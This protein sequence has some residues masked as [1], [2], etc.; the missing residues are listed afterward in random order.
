VIFAFSTY[1]CYIVQYVEFLLADDQVKDD[2][3][4]QAFKTRARETFVC[5]DWDFALR[6]CGAFLVAFVLG[7]TGIHG[8]GAKKGFWAVAPFDS[9]IAGTT[10]YLM[11]A[12]GKGGSAL[13]KNVG[14]FLGTGGGTLLGTM[15]FHIGVDCTW[16]GTLVGMVALL[17]LQFFSFHL[18]FN[19]SQFGYV[20]LLLAA[21][22]GQNLLVPCGSEMTEA[23]ILNIIANQFYA[24]IA[25]TVAELL[26]PNAKSSDL[27]S[28]SFA[29]GNK[30]I[31]ASWRVYLGISS[32]PVSSLKD[33]NTLGMLEEVRGLGKEA[34]IEPRMVR[35]PWRDD[36]WGK[37]LEPMW[38]MGEALHLLTSRSI[39][40]V[41]SP[42]REALAAS[43]EVKQKGEALALT[44]EE[45]FA[46]AVKVLRHDTV[47]PF[48]IPEDVIARLL[49]D[50]RPLSDSMSSMKGVIKQRLAGRV[51]G[52]TAVENATED[53]IC[54]AAM[55]LRLLEKILDSF[56][57]LEDAIVGLP[58]VKK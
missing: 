45:S 6:N 42:V 53:V 55:T 22:G 31:I 15:A 21:Y 4:W 58:E 8:S 1:C 30:A 19:S 56:G 13:A 36:F 18:Y 16:H 28:S 24:I 14:R 46:M 57:R 33:K 23:S 3:P 7:Y 41:A 20:G 38:S 51:K 25:V 39:V 17:A 49:E 52:R 26:L 47:Q 29:D 5:N 34:S 2:S 37:V 27:A 54:Q 50:K 40:S 35:T 11:A 48:D 9:T 43:D 44:A 12:E 32:D 10:A